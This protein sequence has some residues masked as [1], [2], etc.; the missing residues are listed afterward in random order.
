[1]SNIPVT[2]IKMPDSDA[3]NWTPARTHQ[4]PQHVNFYSLHSE[5]MSLLHS[6]WLLICSFCMDRDENAVDTGQ[7]SHKTDMILSLLLDRH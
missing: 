7:E 4:G 2:A 3:S 5:F 1:M 6:M